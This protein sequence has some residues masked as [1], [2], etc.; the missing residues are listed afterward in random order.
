ME[1][2]ARASSFGVLPV[3]VRFAGLAVLI[4]SAM[5]GVACDRA[6]RA[7]ERW[8]RRG[9]SAG[10]G[11]TNALNVLQTATQLADGVRVELRDA[12][13]RPVVDESIAGEWTTSV[14]WTRKARAVPSERIATTEVWAHDGPAP[15]SWERRLT[16]RI[17]DGRFAVRS[18]SVVNRGEV[19]ALG[20][21]GHLAGSPDPAEC[22]DRL[23]QSRTTSV[24][25]L[26]ALTGDL[27]FSDCAAVRPP[28]DA[29][30]RWVLEPTVGT[31][32]DGGRTGWLE[33]SD[34]RGGRVIVSFAEEFVEGDPAAFDGE[35]LNVVRGD[36][37]WSAIDEF[38]EIGR[39]SGWLSEPRAVEVQ[40]P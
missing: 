1:V 39:A 15:V 35:V 14:T 3:R 24:D 36:V 22:L 12:C 27:Q 19:C 2:P 4:V 9:P 40:A 17:P 5:G 7:I 33:W 32:F 29:S 30:V 18:A 26:L 20:L 21:D 31:T 10:V 6:D 25:E 28:L 16:A 37:D 13:V 11:T 8:E 38:V 23:L 34:R